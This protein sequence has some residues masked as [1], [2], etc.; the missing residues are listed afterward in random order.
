R[1]RQ[2]IRPRITA[3]AGHVQTAQRRLKRVL[4]SVGGTEQ[5]RLDSQGTA[6]RQSQPVVLRM[7][8]VKGLTLPDGLLQQALRLF[9]IADRAVNRSHPNPEQR[10]VN[11][12]IEVIG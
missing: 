2:T 8:L 11:L 10:P 4:L 9:A 5:A 12:N 1:Q 3:L 7:G 6:E